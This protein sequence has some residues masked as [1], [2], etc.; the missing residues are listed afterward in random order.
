MNDKMVLAEAEENAPVRQACF[1]RSKRLR[2]PSLAWL[3]VSEETV[4][5]LSPSR[6]ISMVPS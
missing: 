2:K 4:R 1:R 5:I 6:N 3:V